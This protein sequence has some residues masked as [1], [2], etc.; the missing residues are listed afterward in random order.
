[1]LLRFARLRCAQ[2]SEGWAALDKAQVEALAGDLAGQL[3]RLT[4]LLRDLEPP[5]GAAALPKRRSWW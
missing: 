3:A 5:S 2:A 4:G 1:M